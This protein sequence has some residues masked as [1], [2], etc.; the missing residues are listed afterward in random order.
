MFFSVNTSLPFKPKRLKALLAVFQCTPFTRGAPEGKQEADEESLEVRLWLPFHRKIEG[1]EQ[2]E[3]TK[4]DDT[5]RLLD[6]TLFL[7]QLL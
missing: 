3:M 2:R 6:K 1:A 4:C 7:Y 5:W